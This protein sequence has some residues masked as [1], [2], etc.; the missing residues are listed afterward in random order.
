MKNR[1]LCF[2]L[3]ALF[4]AAGSVGAQADSPL[5]LWIRGDL[6]RVTAFDAAPVAL[7]TDGTISGPTVAPDGRRIAY[8]AA[9]QIGMDALDRVDSSGFIADIDLPG[10]IYLLDGADGTPQQIAGQPA[11]ASLL[12]VGIPDKAVIRSTPVWSPD[13]ARIA[14]T[15]FAYPGGQPS[16]IVYDLASATTLTL[17]ADIPTSTVQGA[18]PPV[19]WGTGGIAVNASTDAAGEQDYLIYDANGSL[20]QRPRLAAVANDQV[21]DFAWVEGVNQ[22][23]ILYQSSGWILIDPTT[24]VAQAAPV[25]PQLTTAAPDPLHLRFGA[26][27]ADGFFWEIVGSNAAAS[28]SPRR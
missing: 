22:L 3:I 6:Y 4:L 17:A 13:G 19:R 7:T 16:L 9:D 21:V 20:L 8:K 28:G 5:I 2:C 18:S 25:V 24:G 26:D 10:D 15:E 1:L 23:G 14:W 12:V 27:P 11:D